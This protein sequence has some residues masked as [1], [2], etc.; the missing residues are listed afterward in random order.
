MLSSNIAYATSLS[1][2]TINAT[3]KVADEI[4]RL[5]GIINVAMGIGSFK[6]G[7]NAL[8]VGNPAVEVENHDGLTELQL[9]FLTILIDAGYTVSRDADTGWWYIEWSQD[10][11][12]GVVNVYT[13]RTTLAPGPVSVGTIDLL[14][15]WF[16]A[17]NPS[18]T[19]RI[20]LF[21]PTGSGG[22]VDETLFG[23]SASSFYEYVAVVTQQDT[24]DYSTDIKAALTGSDLGY[25]S[26]NCAVWRVM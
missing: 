20:T 26:G 3:K 23:A 19:S 9:E 24:L 16:L 2:Q 21:N 4:T 18:A 13:I 6:T 10:G 17:H 8:L 22:D 15:A 5:E 1:H 14:D 11:P 25:V 7:Y 12:E